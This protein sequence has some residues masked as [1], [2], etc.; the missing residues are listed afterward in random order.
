[1]VEKDS[2][3]IKVD[4]LLR[5]EQEV[6]QAESVS[7]SVDSD[8]LSYKKLNNGNENSSLISNHNAIGET[9]K[10]YAKLFK[11]TLIRY[12]INPKLI[13]DVGCGAGFLTNEIAKVYPSAEVRGY[14]ISRDAIEYAKKHYRSPLFFSKAI[15]PDTDFEI[16]F[17]VILAKE[18]YPFTRTNSI[19][20]HLSFINVLL[21]NL[22][23]DN[24]AL[25]VSLAH[26]DKCLVNSI[27]EIEK[28]LKDKATVTKVYQPIEKIYRLCPS[29]Y[30]SRIL[31]YVVRHF[32]NRTHAY[33]LIFR[34]ISE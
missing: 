22:S 31:S 9:A 13:A 23:S 33:I 28:K 2:E 25:Y 20:Y 24:S 26:T 14:D 30:V 5:K 15:S 18:F 29:L 1:M 27:E 4:S 12:K 7:D 19:D 3:W 10:F 11:S 32:L 6:Y 16:K 8:F 21:E 17:D 34:P